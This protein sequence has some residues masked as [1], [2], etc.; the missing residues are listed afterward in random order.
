MDGNGSIMRAEIAVVGGGL[1]GMTAALALASAGVDTLLVAAPRRERD[2]R[3]TA[4]LSASVAA[5]EVLGALARCRADAA[6]LKAI[7]IVDDRGAILRGPELFFPASE[8]G[9]EA[10]GC[11]IGNEVLGAALA[12]RLAE[13]P[14][15]RRIDE[16][17]EDLNPG[18]NSVALQTRGGTRIEARLTV[19]ADGR[20]SLCRDAAGIAATTWSY[21]QSALTCS[22]AHTRPH[23]GVSTEFHTAEG[24]FTLVPLPGLRSS[25]VWVMDPRRAE[26]LA[27][28]SDREFADA[29]EAQSRSILGKV[30][31]DGERGAYPLAGL[32]VSRFGQ[33]RIVLVGEAAHL[34]PPIGAQGFNLGLRDA[35]AIAECVAD[36]RRA[37]DDPGAPPVLARYE[38]E[39]RADVATRTLA[40]DL[41]NRSLLT[42][43]IPL[44][45]LRG[46]GLLALER[47]APLRRALVRQ[48]LGAGAKAPRLMRGEAL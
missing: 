39:R 48:G 38:G 21:P 22:F 44:Q 11:N 4:L 13:L 19:G 27:A 46:F 16:A 31:V 3:T 40:V 14:N 7:R 33:N 29:I 9:L 10:F 41:L 36:A 34:I 43:F 12:T 42:G 15:V 17:L 18:E 5:L 2:T 26:R 1:V 6:P 32:S 20:A 37:G 47:I 45:G 35:A 8:V 24:P 28:V 23:R 30:T 25:L